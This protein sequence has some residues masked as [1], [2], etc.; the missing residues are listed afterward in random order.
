MKF[1]N[2]NNNLY[3]WGIISKLNAIHCDSY[4]IRFY[5]NGF[6]NNYKNAS[7]IKYNEYKQFWINS[8]FYGTNNDFTK[9]SWRRFVKMQVFL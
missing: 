4:A 6:H 3:Y 7:V 1:Y 9:Q 2:G 5:K 8:E